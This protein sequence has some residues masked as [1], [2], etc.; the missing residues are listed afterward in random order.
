MSVAIN[1]FNTPNPALAEVV[2]ARLWAKSVAKERKRLGVVKVDAPKEKQGGAATG[3]RAAILRMMA[4]GQARDLRGIMAGLN[5][6]N[7]GSLHSAIKRASDTGVLDYTI[8]PGRK[9]F[10][11]ISAK[12]REVLAKLEAEE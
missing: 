9:W 10:Y 12:G 4:D 8:R 1:L 6:E 3:R 11:T 5:E 2:L 7:S